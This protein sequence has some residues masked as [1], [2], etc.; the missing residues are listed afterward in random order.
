MV[1]LRVAL[2]L[3]VAAAC[4]RAAVAQGTC[5]YYDS[6]SRSGPSG[7]CKPDVCNDK[8]GAL[9]RSFGLWA[10]HSDRASPP[11]SPIGRLPSVVQH[12]R[13]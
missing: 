3:T 8:L 12:R 1:P 5:F 6:A 2:L 10:R 11:A 7:M 9:A 13:T 4:A